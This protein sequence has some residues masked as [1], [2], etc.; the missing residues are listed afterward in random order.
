[1]YWIMCILSTNSYYS[2]TG[3]I[4][5]AINQCNQLDSIIRIEKMSALKKKKVNRCLI[6]KGQSSTPTE[7]QDTL[8][9]IEWQGVVPAEEGG[10]RL[11]SPRII[12]SLWRHIVALLIVQEV[13]WSR[14]LL[15]RTHSAN[16]EKRYHENHR[17]Q[18]TA[19]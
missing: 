10:N 7:L 6:R 2:M 14:D 13:L 3:D 18:E 16:P 9:P 4:N 19:Y 15:D 11:I 8:R 12:G 1:M 5:E 17:E